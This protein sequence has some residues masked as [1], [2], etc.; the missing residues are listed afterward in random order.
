VRANPILQYS[1]RLREICTV[2]L[3]LAVAFRQFYSRRRPAGRRQWHPFSL[4]GLTLSIIFINILGIAPG[5]RLCLQHRLPADV[6]PA[7]EAATCR[8]PLPWDWPAC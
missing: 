2:M 5:A 4:P 1:R 7:F 6:V 8:E 3:P